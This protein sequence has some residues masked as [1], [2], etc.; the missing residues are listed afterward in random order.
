MSEP[1]MNTPPKPEKLGAMTE[2]NLK[3]AFAGESLE[4][5]KV[6]PVRRMLE[7]EVRRRVAYGGLTEV[8]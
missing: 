7:T 2:G 1:F 8:V 4:R 5:M 3:D 6:E